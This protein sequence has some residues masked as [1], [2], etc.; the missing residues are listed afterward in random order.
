M[1]LLASLFLAVFVCSFLSAPGL[2]GGWFWDIGNGIG[3][4]ALVCL[5][6]LGL[7]RSKSSTWRNHQL[8]GY[9]ALALVFG[10][11]AW[12]LLGDP[13]V[14]EYVLPGAPGYMW[15]GIVSGLGVLILIL[16]SMPTLRSKIHASHRN[17]KNLHL[18]LSVFTIAAGIY[19]IIG[20]GFY[21]RSWYEG[22]LLSLII[23]FCMCMPRVKQAFIN[24]QFCKPRAVFIASILAT[25]VFAGIRNVL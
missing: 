8:V 1:W 9:I 16:I 4:A 23:I 19:H 10:H 5:L 22:A 20:S 25:V 21:F 18:W 24:A 7:D 14:L 12:F 15:G 11:A 2:D 3:L 17:F 6:V 13:I